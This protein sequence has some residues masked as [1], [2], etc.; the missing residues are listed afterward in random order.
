MN[1][2]IGEGGEGRGRACDGSKVVYDKTVSGRVRRQRAW[3]SHDGHRG[4]GRRR[5]KAGMS[6][7]EEASATGR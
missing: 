7:K 5:H 6:G 3:P 4:R 2:T 1:D